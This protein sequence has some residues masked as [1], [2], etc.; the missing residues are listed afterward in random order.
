MPL[1]PILKRLEPKQ[2]ARGDPRKR[3]SR[4][5]SQTPSILPNG[6]PI[7]V[8]TPTG[9]PAPM[10]VQPVPVG[11]P[12][13]GPPEVPSDAGAQEVVPAPKKRGRVSK[14]AKTEEAYSAFVAENVQPVEI[15]LRGFAA[16]ADLT[17]FQ[18]LHAADHLSKICKSLPRA[19][20]SA[21]K[22]DF[23]GSALTS[24]QEAADNL[25]AI[26][27]IIVLLKSP[28]KMKESPVGDRLQDHAGQL[29][30]GGHGL[31]L[32][33]VVKIVSM[34]VGGFSKLSICPQQNRSLS[35]NRHLTV[36]NS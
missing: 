30:G 28:K 1:V 21:A 36:D 3:H 2:P 11:P 26:Q 20:A 13:S 12:P 7:P 24:I 29:V 35:I 16:S 33:V 8:S 25:K 6:M 27:C 34:P 31:P 22:Q 19:K 9:P 5:V 17:A 10:P 15:I 23:P 32:Y 14:V 4:S 18:K